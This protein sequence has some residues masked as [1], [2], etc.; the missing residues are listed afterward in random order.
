M[1][2]RSRHSDLIRRWLDQHEAEVD[3]LA[4]GRIEF[5]FANG[6]PPRVEVKRAEQLVAAVVAPQLD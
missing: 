2:E 4:Y 1:A 5:V 3:A 6:S